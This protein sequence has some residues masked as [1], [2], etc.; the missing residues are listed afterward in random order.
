MIEFLINE[1]LDSNHIASQ[2]IP[3]NIPIE[4]LLD[5]RKRLRSNS[6]NSQSELNEIASSG[7][8]NAD[9]RVVKLRTEVDS[10]SRDIDAIDNAIRESIELTSDDV[11]KLQ[12]KEA[13]EKYDEAKTFL[14]TEITTMQEERYQ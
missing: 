11:L 14:E 13:L 5:I 3:M 4:T 8:T 9:E 6:F 2:I 10:M 12:Y 7:A 1:P